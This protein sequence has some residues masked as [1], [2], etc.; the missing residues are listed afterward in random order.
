L[1]DV[2]PEMYS[3]D[4]QCAN[5]EQNY[6]N[7]LFGWKFLKIEIYRDSGIHGFVKTI[8]GTLIFN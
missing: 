4:G 1:V 6:Q 8:S 7:E 5:N 2:D 3:N